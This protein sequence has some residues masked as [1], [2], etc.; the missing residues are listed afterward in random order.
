MRYLLKYTTQYLLKQNK[1]EQN[2]IYTIKSS[3]KL[4]VTSLSSMNKHNYFRKFKCTCHNQKVQTKYKL[5]Q[6]GMFL[7]T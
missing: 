3:Q 5:N 7:K 6:V 1:K 4:T 2:Y